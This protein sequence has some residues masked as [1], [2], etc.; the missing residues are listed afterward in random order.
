MPLRLEGPPSPEGLLEW[1][2]EGRLPEAVVVVAAGTLQQEAVEEPWVPEERK[3]VLAG[4]VVEEGGHMMLP[5]GP[6]AVAA[7]AAAGRMLARAEVRA[8]VHAEALGI[9]EDT[10]TPEG[11]VVADEAGRRIPVRAVVVE[12]TTVPAGQVAAVVAAGRRGE[13]AQQALDGKLV[14][15]A[16]QHCS[17]GDR[18]R[19]AVA[20]VAAVPA[21]G[22]RR[23]SEAD[24]CTGVWATMAAQRKLD[25][26][27]REEAPE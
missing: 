15:V 25:A 3:P 14:P 24:R 16:E 17:S 7:A 20:V 23:D 8:E 22:A 19:V 26:P 18:N 27:E 9:A 10:T 5:G 21:A 13:E 4:A 11:P 1:P 2:P 6:A 12:G